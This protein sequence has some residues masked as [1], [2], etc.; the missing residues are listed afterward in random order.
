M[1]KTIFF[2]IAF[3]TIISCKCQKSLESETKKQINNEFQIVS[4][5][6]SIRI[7][8]SIIVNKEDSTKEIYHYKT[9]YVTT[10]KT[11][12]IY[13]SDTIYITKPIIQKTKTETNLFKSQTTKIAIAIICIMILAIASFIH[14]KRG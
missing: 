14:T 11:D 2:L 8:D 4:K 1:Y 13:I 12:S 3:T 9:S 6:D 5:Y 10:T 7:Y